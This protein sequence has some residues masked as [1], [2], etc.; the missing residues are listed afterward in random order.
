VSAITENANL[1]ECYL[2]NGFMWR[3]HTMQSYEMGVP[4]MQTLML[5]GIIF[6]LA[7]SVAWTAFLGLELFRLIGLMF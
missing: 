3:Y 7:A 5:A 1:E 2:F 6:G 4:V